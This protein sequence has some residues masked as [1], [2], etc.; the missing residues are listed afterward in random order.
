MVKCCDEI[1]WQ[2]KNFCQLTNLWSDFMV[3]EGH[4][5]RNLEGKSW[6]KSQGVN[7]VTDF[8]HVVL[9]SLLSHTFHNQLPRD[10]LLLSKNN[11]R[12][13][14]YVVLIVVLVRGSI[15]SQ[16]SWPQSSWGGKGLF[17]LHFHPAVH[18]QRNSGQELKQ[19]R[20]QELMQRPWRDVLYWLASPGLL[21]LLSYRTQDYQPINGPTY[22]W[23]F[24]LDH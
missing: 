22:N 12:N 9:L 15:P 4:C 5:K 1:T 18:H 2:R 10:S 19:V 20:K 11:T 7:L 14:V 23:P 6:S 3:T 8:L 24:P 16:T 17:G 21:S 13:Y